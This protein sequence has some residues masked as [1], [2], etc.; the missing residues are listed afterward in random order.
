MLWAY[1][2]VPSLERPTEEGGEGLPFGP[3]RPMPL[4]IPPSTVLALLCTEVGGVM[5]RLLG[6]RPGE[7]SNVGEYGLSL[8][9]MFP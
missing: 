8:V 3:G 7:Y 1:K 9:F 6:G 2:P 5:P 4:S